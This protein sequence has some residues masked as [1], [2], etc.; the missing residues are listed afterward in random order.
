M[1]FDFALLAVGGLMLYY[2]AEWLVRG[3]A[4]LARAFGVTPFV[5]GAT[6]VAYG[7]S[8][9]ELTV[10]VAATLDGRGAIAI[11]NVVGSNIANIGLILGVTALISPPRVEGGLIRREIPI[12]VLTTLA[13]VGCVYDGYVGRIEGALL[14]FGAVAF[15]FWMLRS[16]PNPDDTPDSEIE[17]A[18]PKNLTRPRLIALSS[19][20]LLILV[21]GGKAMSE[22][23][24]GLT[25]VAV[26]TSLPELA[27]SLVAAMRGHSDLAVGNVIGSNIFNIL[28]IIGASALVRPLEAP[29]EGVWLDLGA[30]LAMTLLSVWVMRSKR[31]MHRMEGVLLL[32]AYAAFIVS[33]FFK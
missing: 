25:I 26:G 28:L 9:P 4:G 7:T 11:G 18:I 27:A 1:L 12:M 13:L 14:T 10:G 20:G 23:T 6:V 24:V 8:A 31:A 3:S 32:A 21:G 22:R 17:E 30:V 33:L 5:I 19:V 29:T 2:G 15:T 16:N